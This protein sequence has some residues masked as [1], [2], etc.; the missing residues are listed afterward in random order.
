[1][2]LWCHAS[3]ICSPQK[4]LYLCAGD[5]APYGV[6]GGYRLRQQIL[7]LARQ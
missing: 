7:H 4:S 3:I 5:S 6:A 2:P 1:M